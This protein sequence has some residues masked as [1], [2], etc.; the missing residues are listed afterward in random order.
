MPDIQLVGL[1]LLLTVAVIFGY[2]YLKRAQA[3]TAT[4]VV[5]RDEAPVAPADPVAPAVTE[6][7][8]TTESVR[9]EEH[10]PS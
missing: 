9:T 1:I 7:V 2:F 5:T 4:T 8:T 10:P 3:R 6:R